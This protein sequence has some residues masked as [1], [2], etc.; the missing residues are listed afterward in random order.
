MKRIADSA[1]RIAFLCLCLCLHLFLNLFQVQLT[2][3]ILQDKANSVKPFL[4]FNLTL[5]RKL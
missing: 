4:N 5:V 3:D 1:K 2:M